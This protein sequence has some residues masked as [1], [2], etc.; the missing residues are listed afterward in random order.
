MKDHKPVHRECDRCA[1]SHSPRET[2]PAR[3]KQCMKCKKYNHFPKACK[4][5]NT[6]LSK[7]QRRPVHAIEQNNEE[8]QCELYIDSITT[9]NTNKKNV[10]AYVDI[11]VGPSQQTIRFKIDSGAEINAIPNNTFNT[12]FK[13]VP[14]APP[15]QSI[16]AYGGNALEV[17]GTCMLECEHNNHPALVEFHIIKAKAP[18]ILGLG[19]SLDLNLIKLV[20]GVNK[21]EIK[22]D[23]E[24]KTILKEYADVF[25]GIGE[26]AGECTLRVNSNAVPVVYPPRRVPI[27]L[28]AR[29]KES[30]NRM[31][32]NNIIV[33]VTEPTEWINALVVVEKPKSHIHI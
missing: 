12:L 15:G 32:D 13:S 19:A 20:M 9:V 29:L 33:K 8:E 31:E 21:E 27:A 30:L 25:Q 6:A 24:P 28:R 26:F 5:K 1:G 4:T 23:N 7:P 2:C 22:I 3:G 18:P 17:R 10:Q 16:T 14:I 11:K